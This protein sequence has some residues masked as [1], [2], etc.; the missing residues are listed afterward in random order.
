MPKTNSMA[1]M[2]SE[3]LA[4]TLQAQS[5]GLDLLLSEMRALS[6]VMPGGLMPTLV[7]TEAVA[8]TDEADFDNMPV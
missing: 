6:E 7:P 8:E 4:V 3:M 2:T 5:K 1:E